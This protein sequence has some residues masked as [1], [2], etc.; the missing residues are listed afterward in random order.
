MYCV[1]L[2]IKNDKCYCASSFYFRHRFLSQNNVS[3]L[4]FR[5]IKFC[6]SS[7]DN[8]IDKHFESVLQRNLTAIYHIQ[9]HSPISF[10]TL[11][12]STILRLPDARQQMKFVHGQRWEKPST[13]EEIWRYG[14]REFNRGTNHAGMFLPVPLF[15][16]G[17]APLA[18]DVH[19]DGQFLCKRKRQPRRSSTR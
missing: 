14:K 17:F 19:T 2:R 7:H 1:V 10:S 18:V 9:L 12:N 11:R 5:G 13:N 4:C 6:N 15:A 3:L 8:H 16:P